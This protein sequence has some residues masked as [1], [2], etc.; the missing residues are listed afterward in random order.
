MFTS[1]LAVHNIKLQSKNIL[2]LASMNFPFTASPLSWPFAWHHQE[3]RH[4]EIH[5]LT[6]SNV[7]VVAGISSQHLARGFDLLRC[8]W[9]VAGKK[10]KAFWVDLKIQERCR[11]FSGLHL[12]NSTWNMKIKSD[13]LTT[14]ISSL[15]SV[16]C[17]LLSPPDFFF[18]L[19]N[20]SSMLLLSLES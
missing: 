20:I 14:K 9:K 7:W 15:L 16:L 3:Q 8:G 2:E 19:Q 18:F 12:R 4:H 1:Y 11:P 13:G 6:V 17:P 10:A 5:P